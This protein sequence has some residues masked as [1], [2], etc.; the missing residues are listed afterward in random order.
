M[1]PELNY[2]SVKSHQLYSPDLYKPPTSSELVS[3]RSIAGASSSLN[4]ERVTLTLQDDQGTASETEK[5]D[6]YINYV[7]KNSA[8][9]ENRGRK[10]EREQTT[11]NYA[12]STSPNLRFDKDVIGW[13]QPLFKDFSERNFARDSLPAPTGANAGFNQV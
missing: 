4:H 5:I 12:A 10:A 9:P 2:E 3:Q 11:K 1:P 13:V 6:I 7:E 8:Q